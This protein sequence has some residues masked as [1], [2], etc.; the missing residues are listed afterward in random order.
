MPTMKQYL[1]ALTSLES[2]LPPSWRSLLRSHWAAPRHFTF[3]MRPQ[4]ARA[5]EIKGWV[6][7]AKPPAEPTDPALYLEGEE[8]RLFLLHR[9][10]DVKLR[11]AKIRDV[12]EK[13]GSL[14]CEVPGCGFDF[15]RKYGDL[16]QGF[17]EV[18]HLLP[19]YKLKRSRMNRLQDVAIV[20]SNCHC[21]IHRYG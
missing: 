16:G 18:H 21:M 20:C 13:T 3:R 19:L 11:N 1:R 6:K 9:S 17:A 12:L 10:R 2:N 8:R 15:R 5:L 14:R 7:G 4:L